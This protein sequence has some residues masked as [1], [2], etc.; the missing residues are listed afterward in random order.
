M[1]RFDV[2]RL[3]FVLVIVLIANTTFDV[4]SLKAQGRLSKVR[5][6]VRRHETPP[7]SNPSHHDD[8]DD[9]DDDHH[10]DHGGHF[11]LNTWSDNCYDR[12]RVV[13]HV[14]V[15]EPVPVLHYVPPVTDSKVVAAEPV[16]IQQQP[17]IA[18]PTFESYFSRWGGR[19]TAFYGNEFDDL[20]HGSLAVLF[21]SPGFLGLDAS[22]SMFRESAGTFRDH[23]WVGDVNVVYEAINT[24]D[25]RARLGVGINWLG[26]YYGGDAGANL[27]FGIDW[28]IHPDWVVTG[29]TDFGNLGDTDL[30]HAQ[31][32][33]GR[34]FENAEW[35][36]GYDYYDIG[37][38]TIGGVFTGLRFRF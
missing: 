35:S 33:I 13:E 10:N 30:L 32:S 2:F 34:Q 27:T 12:P 20:S 16:V 5:D 28:Q 38:A 23:L 8:N 17:V 9:H 1:N 11:W 25:F 29:E 3:L 18:A 37:G 26:D 4:S 31:L 14:H 15:Y 7:A 6:N 21:Q 24:D 19:V 22:V 36:T